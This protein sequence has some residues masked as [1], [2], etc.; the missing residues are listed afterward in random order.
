M[1]EKRREEFQQLF[2]KWIDILTTRGPVDHDE[3]VRVLQKLCGL[4]RIAKGTV[5]FYQTF[6]DERNRNGEYF[7]DCDNGRGDVEI[8]RIR[9]V[10]KSSTVI[11]GTLYIAKEDVPL[12]EEEYQKADLVM[13]SLLSF[14]GRARM[15]RV[16]ERLGFYDES[17]WPNLRAYMRYLEQIN[18]QGKLYG[19]TAICY[20]LRHFSLINEEIGRENGDIVMHNYFELMKE[21]IGDNGIVCHMGGD[22]FVAIFKTQL[23]EHILDILSGIPVLYDKVNEKRVMVSA[24]TG[25]FTIPENFV[26]KNTG[27]IMD[28]IIASSQ[29]ARRSPDHSIIFY[30]AKM[31]EMREHALRI[32]R[33]F[34]EALENREFKV[35]YQ[36]KVDVT[37]GNMVGAEALCRWFRNGKIVP[38]MEFIPIFEQS[39]TICQLDFY[40][41]DQVCRDIRRWLNEGRQP[42]R[43]SVNL[44]RKHLVD[45]DLLDHLTDIIHNN[46]VPPQYIEIELTETT[47]EVGFR[48]L[49]NV[50]SG[51]Q[52]EGV[53]TSVDDFG[54]GYSS[55]NLIRQI[56]WNVLKIDKSFLPEDDEDPTSITNIMFKHVVSMAQD[57][58]LECITEGVETKKQVELLQKTHCN[59]AQGY[60]FDKPLPVAEFEE[61]LL[62]R[63]YDV[64][65]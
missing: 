61:R 36:P 59:I 47:T 28:K 35:F 24:S 8:N 30:N 3:L 49:S 11:I 23:L 50:V 40:M 17:G 20:N 12:S 16:V 39:D 18:E 10:T 57:M 25:V 63:K 60:Y 62:H 51:L 48:A 53:R 58:G 54:M 13:R 4:L 6:R 32:Q 2:E 56:P 55:L 7:C 43:I 45:V 44:S 26:M 52:Q 65:L 31:L 1:D 27:M 37:T 19:H 42:V 64:K 46:N 22:N 15:E 33:M 9:I 21:T 5:E 34:P 38:P 41:L 14:M 29:A